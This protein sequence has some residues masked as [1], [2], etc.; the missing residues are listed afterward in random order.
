[1]ISFSRFKFLFY[2]VALVFLIYLS[3]TIDKQV[4]SLFYHD[5]S[6]ADNFIVQFIYKY[7]ILPGWL[8]FI[9]SA[10][11]FFYTFFN[12]KLKKF[13]PDALVIMLSLVIGSGLISHLVFKELWHRSR[14]RQTALFG[15]TENFTP[16]YHPNFGSSASAKSFV[17]GHC[18]MGFYF[19]SLSEVARR[20]KNKKLYYLA[21][22]LAISLGTIL[23]VTRIAQGG[24]FL[25]DVIAA[26]VIMWA[27]PKLLTVLIFRLKFNQSH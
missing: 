11:T 24:H 26:A 6:F 2:L 1:M 21:M 17:C 27:V 18:T 9:A 7:A 23:G 25:T 22:T 8:L 16:F 19:F 4:S 13:R 5:H 20:R 12:P 3:S 15:G 14:P 10:A